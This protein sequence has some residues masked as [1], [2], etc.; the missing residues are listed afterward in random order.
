MIL[1]KNFKTAQMQNFTNILFYVHPL[2]DQ[3]TFRVIHTHLKNS[4]SITKHMLANACRTVAQDWPNQKVAWNI[5][6]DM[7]KSILDE[8]RYQNINHNDY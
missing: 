8:L 7:Q 4:C 6:W 1:L 5:I 2:F 3:M